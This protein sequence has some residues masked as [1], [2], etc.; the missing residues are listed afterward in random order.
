VFSGWQADR[1]GK[2]A[3]THPI[4]SICNLDFGVLA[5]IEGT[6]KYPD[7]L[8][9]EDLLTGMPNT[10][11][12]GLR[13]CSTPPVPL[14]GLARLAQTIVPIWRSAR[15]IDASVGRQRSITTPPSVSTEVV[16]AF[17]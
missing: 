10:R 13:V 8:P 9:P 4:H 1:S 14:A 15:E 6:A 5:I 7:T 3:D 11:N 17:A 16:A 12:P 2:I